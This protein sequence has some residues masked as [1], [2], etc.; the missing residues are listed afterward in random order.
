[1][2]NKEV[3]DI[4]TNKDHEKIIEL[5]NKDDDFVAVSSQ[6]LGVS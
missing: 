6:V 2:K 4:L 5:G 3:K 1:M